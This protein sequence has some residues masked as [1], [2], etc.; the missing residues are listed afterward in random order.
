MFDWAAFDAA[1]N[2]PILC[3]RSWAIAAVEHSNNAVKEEVRLLMESKFIRIVLA[4]MHL[5]C[6][7]EYMT[8]SLLF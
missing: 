1:S 6:H 8:V 2:L 7:S 5:P 3:D 4:R